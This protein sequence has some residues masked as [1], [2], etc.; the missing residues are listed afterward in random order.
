MPPVLL[1][2]SSL[3]KFSPGWYSSALEHSHGPRLDTW[4][5]YLPTLWAGW[6]PCT[7]DLHSLWLSP[8]LEV[9]LRAHQSLVSIN[10][11]RAHPCL[12]AETGKREQCLY[13]YTPA[14]VNSDIL[15]SLWVGLLPKR[16]C[17]ALQKDFF[18]PSEWLIKCRR[19]REEKKMEESADGSL[20]T[21]EERCEHRASAV[22]GRN[23]SSSIWQWF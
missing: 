5:R 15:T 7:P 18:V 6:K 19:E 2:I 17:R 11:G 21:A 1:Q 20:R 9:G 14:I 22:S 3:I 13:V 4:R 23:S 16:F 12:P 8:C 10:P